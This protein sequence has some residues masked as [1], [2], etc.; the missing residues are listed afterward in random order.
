MVDRV[1]AAQRA[2]EARLKAA[3]EG[4]KQVIGKANLD[5]HPTTFCKFLSKSGDR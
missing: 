3:A 1:A 5:F 2:E 4:R